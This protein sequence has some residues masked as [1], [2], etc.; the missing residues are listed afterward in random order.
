MRPIRKGSE[1]PSLKKHRAIPHSDYDNYPEKDELRASL[2]TEQGAIC[3]YCMQR[4]VGKSTEMKIEHWACQ[5]HH[6]DQDLDY[7]NLLGACL[8]GEGKPGRY[9]HCDTYKGNKA[10]GRHPAVNPPRVDRDMHYLAD[11]T[12]TSEDATFNGELDTVL[13]LNLERLKNNRKAVLDALKEWAETFTKLRKTDVKA[14]LKEWSEMED[15]RL[16]EYVQ[17]A[18]YWLSKRLAKF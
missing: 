7:G 6:A 9:Q 4:I 1:P 12:V 10:L 2:V 8:G 14:E 11:G 16:R 15:G 3:C 13:H 18:V 17:V 5:D